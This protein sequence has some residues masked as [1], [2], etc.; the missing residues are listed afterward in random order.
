MPNP[1]YLPKH[2]KTMTVRVTKDDSQLDSGY[3]L[4]WRVV[5]MALH[6]DGER[7]TL[8]LENAEGEK[9]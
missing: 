7:I 8:L 6:A 4:G 5:K 2:Y 9:S 3:E 1:T